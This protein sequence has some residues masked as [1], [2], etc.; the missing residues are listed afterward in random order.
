MLNTVYYVVSYTVYH[1]EYL[2][3]CKSTDCLETVPPL[4]T[5]V[6]EGHGPGLSQ[7]DSTA[8][9]HAGHL[10]AGRSPSAQAPAQAESPA[11]TSAVRSLIFRSHLTPHSGSLLLV[12]P[13]SA[14]NAFLCVDS[15]EYR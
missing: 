14:F 2:T 4:R 9:A 7:V 5:P 3:V 6:P 1:P 10:A 13:L 8:P 11:G 15:L 12:T